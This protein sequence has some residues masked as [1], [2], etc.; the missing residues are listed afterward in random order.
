VSIN[1]ANSKP[2]LLAETISLGILSLPWAISVLGAIPGTLTIAG[3]GLL[4][5][6]TGKIYGDFKLK[7]PQVIDIAGAGEILFARFGYGNAGRRLF[8]TASNLVLVFIMA[9]HVIGFVHM[10]DVSLQST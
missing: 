7:H 6:Y 9:A 3:F 5:T 1:V 10:M 2:V 8:A 4:S